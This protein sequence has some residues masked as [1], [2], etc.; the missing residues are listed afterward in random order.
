[1][2]MS[3]RLSFFFQ[4]P[5]CYRYTTQQIEMISKKVKIWRKSVHSRWIM[6]A[7]SRLRYE[8]ISKC[9]G[10]GLKRRCC[11]NLVFSRYCNASRCYHHLSIA[12]ILKFILSSG[13]HAQK[14]IKNRGVM[15]LQGCHNPHN[16][17]SDRFASIQDRIHHVSV[18]FHIHDDI[19]ICWQQ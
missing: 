19:D 17:L 2:L 12:S 7:A 11:Q 5:V 18:I 3:K 15:Q 1:M 14:M 16:A 4:L 10:S 8:F 9:V 13:C 6:P